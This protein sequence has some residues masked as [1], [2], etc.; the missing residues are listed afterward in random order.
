M[1]QLVSSTLGQLWGQLLLRISLIWLKFKDLDDFSVASL[2]TKNYGYNKRSRAPKR[3]VE[4]SLIRDLAATIPIRLSG[5]PHWSWSA[6]V[7][8]TA[9]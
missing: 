1:D 2:A 4:S 8:P 7:T 3:I 6:A 9:A 5:S